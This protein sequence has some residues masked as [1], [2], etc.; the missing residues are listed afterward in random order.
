MYRTNLTVSVTVFTAAPPTF[1]PERFLPI[2]DGTTHFV[3]L[4]EIHRGDASVSGQIYLEGIYDPVNERFVFTDKSKNKL[5]DMFNGTFPNAAKMLRLV[6][7]VV[8]I[9][10]SSN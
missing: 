3:D 6:E 9:N 10:I 2:T 1:V 8:A 4:I 5:A 7:Q